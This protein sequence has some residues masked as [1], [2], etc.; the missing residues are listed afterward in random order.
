VFEAVGG[1]DTAYDPTCFEDTDLSLL[2][3]DNGYEL[4]YC[5]SLLIRHMAHQTTEADGKDWHFDLLEKNGKYFFEKW[6]VRNK[7]LLEYYY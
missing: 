2:I 1:F 7:K 4:A 5:P 3:R 6:N